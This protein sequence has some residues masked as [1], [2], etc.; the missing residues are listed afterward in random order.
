MKTGKLREDKWLVLDHTQPS[1]RAE[2][3]HTFPYSWSPQLPLERSQYPPVKAAWH[4][5]LCQGSLLKCVLLFQILDEKAEAG[6]GGTAFCLISS[7]ITLMD[8][9]V[10]ANTEDLA[11]LWMFHCITM[12]P[13]NTRISTVVLPLEEDAS[14]DI[15]MLSAALLFVFWETDG[16]PG[17]AGRQAALSL[18]F[19]SC[20]SV[21][22]TPTRGNGPFCLKSSQD[23]PAVCPVGKR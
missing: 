13:I 9:P 6:G 17:L 18:Q 19:L 15:C 21:I 23:C 14:E 22:C 1:V 16:G 11:C 3:D 12:L 4:I 10:L 7:S 20:L 8:L 2:P 5:C